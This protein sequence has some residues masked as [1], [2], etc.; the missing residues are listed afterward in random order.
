MNP[1]VFVHGLNGYTEQYHPIIKFL[2][3]KGFEKFYCFSY[4]NKFGLSSL[5][6][7]AHELA[8][9][10]DKNITE[11]KFDIIA[12]SQGGI[13]AMDYLKEYKN[14]KVDKLFTVC[15]PHR[16]S[17]LA[18]ISNLP[19]IKDLRP[20][21]DLINELEDFAK[22]NHINLYSIYT[23]FDLMVFP[24]WNARSKYGKKKIIFAPTHPSA[25]SWPATMKFIYKNLKNG[26][27]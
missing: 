14:K 27:R 16:G 8:E 15:T 7:V 24:G 20:K 25:F 17:K 12:F 9:F 10:V 4:N 22:N 26:N 21:S 13:I 18:K 2:R 6:I 1:I 5:R 11:E 3:E 23:P 19:G